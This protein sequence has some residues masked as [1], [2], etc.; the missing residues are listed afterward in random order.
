MTS[1]RRKAFTLLE[2]VATVTMI[3]LLSA[4]AMGGYLKFRNDASNGSAQS[5]IDR[6][7]NVERS[8]ANS[9][10]TYTGVAS[11]LRNLD[12]EITLLG[13]STAST[14]DSQAS[15]ALGSQG[16]LGVAVK[17]RSGTCYMMSMASLSAGFGAANDTRVDASG[18]MQTM[19]KGSI[20]TGREALSAL[21]QALDAT[22]TTTPKR[23]S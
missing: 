11:D 7:V 10:G 5:T 1:R 3:A 12:S 4:L 13:A 14:S 19:P 20:C 22:G 8:F 21:G 6:V 15:I 16:G 18:S 17:S 9:F 23:T 2:M